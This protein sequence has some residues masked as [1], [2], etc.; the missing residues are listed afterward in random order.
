MARRGVEG[1]SPFTCAGACHQSE[2]PIYLRK[3]FYDNDDDGGDDGDG[4]IILLPY[5]TPAVPHLF[6]GIEFNASI[7]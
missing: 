3:Y 7:L 5:W 2:Y 4:Y 6:N 1:A